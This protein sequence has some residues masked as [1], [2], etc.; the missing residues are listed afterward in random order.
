MNPAESSQTLLLIWYQSIFSSIFFRFHSFLFR[1]LLDFF[2]FVFFAIMASSCSME[3][4]LSNSSTSST[5][6]NSTMDSIHYFFTIVTI[7]VQWLFPL[8]SMEKTTTH[9]LDPCPWPWRQKTS[10]SSSIVNCQNHCLLIHIT[11]HGHVAIIWFFLGSSILWRRKLQP[12]SF[13]LIQQK[14][15]EMIFMIAF[16]NK[17]AQGSSKFIRQFILSLRRINR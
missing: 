17:M 1:F 10:V 14:L 11:S 4:N 3:S 5:S 6:V 8:H 16:L 9:G 7:L 13:L 15:C 2:F 12:V